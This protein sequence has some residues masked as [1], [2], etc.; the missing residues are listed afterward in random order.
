MAGRTLL[1]RHE[2]FTSMHTNQRAGPPGHHPDPLRL[3]LPDRLRHVLIVGKTGTGKSTLLRAIAENDLQRGH[4][5]LLL[6]PHGDL[7]MEVGAD[8]PRFRKNDIV[9]TQPFLNPV[10]G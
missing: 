3:S 6:D 4:G 9:S 2:V 5:F 8:I 10:P 7:A 1:M